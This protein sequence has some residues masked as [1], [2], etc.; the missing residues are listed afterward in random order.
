MLA[1][2]FYPDFSRNLHTGERETV[3]ATMRKATL[4]IQHDAPSRLVLP[5][6]PLSGRVKRDLVAL[7]AREHD[8][9]VD[10]G[11]IH[12]VAPAWDAARAGSARPSSKRRTSAGARRGTASRRST[13]ACAT[14]RR[15]TLRGV[16]ESVR[17]RRALLAIAAGPG[18][19]LAFV[20]PARLRASRGAAMALAAALWPPPTSVS[21]GP[22]RELPGRTR[23]PRSRPILSRAEVAADVPAMCGART[24]WRGLWGTRRW[25]AASG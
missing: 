11:G 22:Q 5:V 3:S 14:S 9:L 24:V 2:E 23:L 19:P 7:A 21:R 17:E 6:A 1:P 13:A 4:T 16:R 18:R 12:G 15:R 25:T 10:G 20:V 8:V